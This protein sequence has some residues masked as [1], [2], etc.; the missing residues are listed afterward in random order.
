MH[1]S[2]DVRCIQCN[3]NPMTLHAQNQHD[4]LFLWAV[5]I[6]YKMWLVSPFR[7]QVQRN[8]STA[9]NVT[10]RMVMIFCSLAMSGPDNLGHSFSRHDFLQMIFSLETNSKGLPV[11]PM[12]FHSRRATES[13][14]VSLASV[15]RI[16]NMSICL[17]GSK[18]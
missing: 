11:S 17:I 13:T 12:G 5:F 9:R 6:S 7:S 4:P 10:K 18:I 1:S 16:G 15:D 14:L 3:F 8:E 2:S